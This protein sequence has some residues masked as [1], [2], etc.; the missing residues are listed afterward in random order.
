MKMKVDKIF[1]VKRLIFTSVAL[2]RDVLL[3]CYY[4]L[5]N[6]TDKNLPLLLINDGQDLIKMP[7]TDILEYS[8]VNGEM[9]PIFSV[10][11]HCSADRKNEYGTADVL[12]YKG[13]GAKAKLYR[14]FVIKEL[15]PFLKDKFSMYSFTDVS[16]AGFS[17]GALSA[18]D[19]VWSS[20]GVFKN[21][22]AF[23]GSFWWRD[24]SFEDETFDEEKNRIIHKLVREGKYQK[25]LKMFFQVGTDDETQDRNNNGV[26]DSIDDTLSL[27][28]EFVRRGYTEK[29]IEYLELVGG[30]HDVPTWAIALPHFLKYCWGNKE[31]KA[32]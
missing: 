28:A 15:L 17:L 20:P 12:D 2:Q 8:F 31:K 16:L 11:I 9:A 25:Q 24:K 7:F 26:I 13:R 23:S 5:H 27:I 14:T 30:R 21:L 1:A 6:Y 22:G 19:I 10:G 4:P 18:V 29:E 32:Y 3:D